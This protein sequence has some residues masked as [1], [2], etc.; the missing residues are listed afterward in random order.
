MARTPTPFSPV[1]DGDILPVTP[2][3]ALG[4]GAARDVELLIGHTRDE[5]GLL[6]ARLGDIS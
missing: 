4:D 2:W 6:A 3:A 5:F 1:V